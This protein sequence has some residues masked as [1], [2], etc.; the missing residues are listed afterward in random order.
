MK[1]CPISG[2]GVS[3]LWP[4]L[5]LHPEGTEAGW[6]SVEELVVPLGRQLRSFAERSDE[7]REG[8]FLF[9]AVQKRFWKIKI[10]KYTQ[11]RTI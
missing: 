10:S 1:N 8:A 2:P 4:G 5:F 11:Y 7:R 3:G 6:K 9:W